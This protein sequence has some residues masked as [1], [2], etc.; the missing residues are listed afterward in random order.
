LKPDLQSVLEISGQTGAASIAA[1]PIHTGLI[2]EMARGY[3][4]CQ[5]RNIGRDG[6]AVKVEGD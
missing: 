2:N 4:A 6:V 3:V 1:Y 5:G